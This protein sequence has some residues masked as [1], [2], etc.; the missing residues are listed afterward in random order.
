MSKETSRKRDRN[1]VQHLK[2]EIRE[3]L[4]QIR[5][6]E[7]RL[8][9]YERREPSEKIENIKP[10]GETKQSKKQICVQCGKGEIEEF[11][12]M[13]STWHT[14]NLCQSRIKV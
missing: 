7:R 6:L 13:G 5:Q 3:L 11:S 9:Y 4:K 12:F 10:F 2:G 1:E 8:R 14:C